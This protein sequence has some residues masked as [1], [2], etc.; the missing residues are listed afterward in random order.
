M[1][2][3]REIGADIMRKTADFRHFG[4]IKLIL[5]CPLYWGQ[6]TGSDRISTFLRK[7]I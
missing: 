4:A 3:E 1:M 2:G 7:I 6:W 5:F